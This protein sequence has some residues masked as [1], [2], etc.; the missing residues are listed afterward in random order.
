MTTKNK[1]MV[2]ACL[3]GCSCRYNG[4]PFPVEE[5]IHLVETGYA[6]P[7]C[8]EQL[9]GLPTPRSQ[10]EILE[11]D[12]GISI[13]GIDGSDYTSEFKKGAEASLALAE[14]YKIKKAIMKS[15]SPSCGFGEIYDGTFSGC[16]KKGNGITAGLFIK[17]G[18]TI[19]T[20]L[21][22]KNRI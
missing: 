11:T 1:I 12:E 18:I 5:I 15:R 22:F 4:T 14:K 8:P 9:G 3:A 10:C 7:F 20:E 13:I 17:H 6:I 19:Y 16:K 21:T 2:S